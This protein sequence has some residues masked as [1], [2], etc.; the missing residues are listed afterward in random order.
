MLHKFGIETH[1]LL[2]FC[3]RNSMGIVELQRLDGKQRKL[4]D[5]LWLNIGHST[6]GFGNWALQ[7]NANNPYYKIHDNLEKR[8][9]LSESNTNAA[10]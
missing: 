3:L 2:S 4:A 6:I 8:N 5:R 7:N 10:I 1:G 9:Q